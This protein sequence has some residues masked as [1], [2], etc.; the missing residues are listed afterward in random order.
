L[1]KDWNHEQKIVADEREDLST[2][3]S[4]SKVII[5]ARSAN[6]IPFLHSAASTL[7]FAATAASTI[8]P[9]CPATSSVSAA[10]SAASFGGLIKKI[11]ENLSLTLREMSH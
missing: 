2:D 11:N 1:K 3:L 4:E 5:A 7:T 9:T 10:T 8:A 6:P